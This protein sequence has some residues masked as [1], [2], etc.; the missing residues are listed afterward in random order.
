MGSE[1]VFFGWMFPRMW[2]EIWALV[3]I[4]GSGMELLLS[5]RW[6]FLSGTKY[7]FPLFRVYLAAFILV[8]K[9]LETA[10]GLDTSGLEDHEATQR[11]SQ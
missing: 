3:F 8:I 5:L 7:G 6:L 11:S 2:V 9:I 4:L 10:A 1:E